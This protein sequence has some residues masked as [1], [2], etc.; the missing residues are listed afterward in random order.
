MAISFSED[1]L[2]NTLAFN[3]FNKC[4]LKRRTDGATVPV[5]RLDF[6]TDALLTAM[7]YVLDKSQP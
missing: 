2:S 4:E 5:L 6:R 1:L 7:D 3:T